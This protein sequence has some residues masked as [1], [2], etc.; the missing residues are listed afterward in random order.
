VLAW[1]LPFVAASLAFALRDGNRPLFESVMALAVTAAAVTLG[2]AYLKRQRDGGRSARWV[3]LLWLAMCVAI[4][5]PFVL[6]GPLAM[7]WAEYVSDIGLTYAIYPIVVWGQSR[8]YA[9]PET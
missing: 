5:I 4:D 8:S 6:A 9:S 3:G 7:T 1:V 2:R